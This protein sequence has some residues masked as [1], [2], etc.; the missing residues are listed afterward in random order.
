[1]VETKKVEQTRKIYLDALQAY[2]MNNRSESNRTELEKLL[3]VLKE[4]RTLSN[5]NSELF[6]SLKERNINLPSFLAQ[7]WGIQCGT[8]DEINDRPRHLF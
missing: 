7:I 6:F 2:V 4:L 8:A 1:M 3:P 5:L